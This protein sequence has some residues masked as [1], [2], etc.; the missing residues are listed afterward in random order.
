MI[1]LLF[2]LCMVVPS[3]YD[4]SYSVEI[5]PTLMDVN[6]LWMGEDLVGG[7]WNPNTKTIYIAS[8][9]LEHFTAEYRHAFCYHQFVYYSTAHPYCQHPHY[10][11]EGV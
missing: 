6:D 2:F 11:I 7:F 5:L 1:T 10:K 4:C 9:Y 8:T 3:G